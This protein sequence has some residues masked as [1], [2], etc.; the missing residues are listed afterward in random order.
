MLPL[1][2]KVLFPLLDKV[3]Q[4]SDS[5]STD[6]VDQGGNILIHHSRNT[7]QKQW[8]ETQVLTLSGVARVFSTKQKILQGLGDFPRAWALLL[9]FIHTAALSKSNEVCSLVSMYLVYLHKG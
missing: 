6:K 3:R 2:N 7:Q 9:D 4:L 1:S 8:A 5:A